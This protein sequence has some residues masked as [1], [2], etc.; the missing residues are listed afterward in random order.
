MNPIATRGP[1]SGP[2]YGLLAALV[3]ATSAIVIAQRP[4]VPNAVAQFVKVNAPVVALTHVRVIDGTGAP[5]RADQTLV[6]EGD[7]IAALGGAA[8][9]TIPAGAMTIDLTGKS[10]IPGLV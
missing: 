3:F 7:R 2:P 8:S 9:T 6:I 1:K 5:A 10:V 4:A